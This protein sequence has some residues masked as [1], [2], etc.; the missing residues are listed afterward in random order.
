[1]ESPWLITTAYTQWERRRFLTPDRS[2]LKAACPESDKWLSL[3][4]SFSLK[5]PAELS[6]NLQR[7]QAS[8]LRLLPLILSKGQG[9]PLEPRAYMQLL[10]EHSGSTTR[11]S[12]KIFCEITYL[13]RVSLFQH[14]KTE[15]LEIDVT[16]FVMNWH[17]Q[18]IL[19]IH[20]GEMLPAPKE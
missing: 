11:A 6:Q 1:M 2:D 20:H 16:T 3:T 7:Q 19:Q 5:F 14:H 15:I 10:C 17:G 9:Q 18:L 8:L 4:R 13:K 12:M